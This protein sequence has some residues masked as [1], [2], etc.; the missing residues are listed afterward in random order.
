M[1]LMMKLQAG[2]KRSLLLSVHEKEESDTP[3]SPQKTRQ[4]SRKT[5]INASE[6]CLSPMNLTITPG[7]R[8]F[9]N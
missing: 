4:L 5:K 2:H 7:F 3:Q 1:N 8:A 9:F 6:I